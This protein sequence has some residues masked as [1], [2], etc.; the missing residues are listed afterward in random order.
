MFTVAARDQHHHCRMVRSLTVSHQQVRVGLTE[1]L[2]T[3]GR[4]GTMRTAA[5]LLQVLYR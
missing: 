2:E 4:T 5:E 3:D 1:A